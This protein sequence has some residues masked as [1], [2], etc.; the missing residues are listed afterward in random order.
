[1]KVFLC[2]VVGGNVIFPFPNFSPSHEAIHK[3]QILSECGMRGVAVSRTGLSQHKSTRWPQN[4]QRKIDRS[5]PTTFLRRDPDADAD[6]DAAD[7]KKA[8]QIFFSVI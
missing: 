3:R 2:V 7:V 5:D 8:R 6:A 4:P 1:M